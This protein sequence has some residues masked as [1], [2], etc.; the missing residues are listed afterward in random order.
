[1]V[2]PLEFG[3]RRPPPLECHVLRSVHVSFRCGPL[4]AVCN[5][6]HIGHIAACRTRLPACRTLPDRSVSLVSVPS[7]CLSV[8]S[9]TATLS[10]SRALRRSTTSTRSRRCKSEQMEES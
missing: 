6:Y 8:S 7:R 2:Q 3:L 4:R 10:V 9:K 1:M 5:E